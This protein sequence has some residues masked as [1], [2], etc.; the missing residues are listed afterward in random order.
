MPKLIDILKQINEESTLGGGTTAGATFTPGTGEQVA[1]TKGFKPLRKKLTKEDAPMLAAGKA[2]ISTSTKDGFTN[3]PS[4]TNRSSKAIDYKK[5]FEVSKDDIGKDFKVVN[6]DGKRVEAIYKG[7]RGDGD[8]IFDAGSET[9]TVRQKDLNAKVS[10]LNENYNQFRNKTKFRQGPD[11][12]HQAIKEAKKK[13][14][15]VNRLMEYVDRL[16]NELNEGEEGLKYRNHTEK[17]ISQIKESV[18]SLYKK[19]K[20]FK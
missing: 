3:A 13:I 15:E 5:M 14:H 18:V 6:K 7:V 9:I 12:F 8:Y 2:N 11:Q 19:V 10:S 20:S 17:A 16:R 1:T 4:I